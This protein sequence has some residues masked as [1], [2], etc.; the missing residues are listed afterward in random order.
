MFSNSDSTTTPALTEP[1][2]TS[3]RGWV[4][5]FLMRIL[6]CLEVGRLTIVTPSGER[7]EHRGTKPGPEGVLN[8][9]NWRALRRLVTGGDNGFADAYNNG[10][11]PTPDLTA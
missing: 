4:L 6:T 2:A 1:E 10:Y 9:H 8:L 5:F 11:W 7:I 3:I